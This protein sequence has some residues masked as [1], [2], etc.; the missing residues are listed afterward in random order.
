[1]HPVENTLENTLIVVNNTGTPRYAHSNI[2]HVLKNLHAF[3][4]D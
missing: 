2:K 3:M 1:M 4:T